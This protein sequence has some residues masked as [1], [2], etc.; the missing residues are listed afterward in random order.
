MHA[1][2]RSAPVYNNVVTKDGTTYITNGIGGCGEGL[3][4]DFFF[5]EKFLKLFFFLKLII[6]TTHQI[7]VSI[8]KSP[9]FF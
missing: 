6:G 8:G 9:L 3:G 1:Y 4:L 2:E 7:G 5:S